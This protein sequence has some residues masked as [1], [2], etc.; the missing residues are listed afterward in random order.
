MDMITVSIGALPITDI[1]CLDSEVGRA[2]FDSS[3][4]DHY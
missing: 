2:I 3:L 1:G 4:E